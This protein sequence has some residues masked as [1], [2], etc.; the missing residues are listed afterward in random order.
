MYKVIGADGMEYGPITSDQLQP[1]IAD[2]RVNA[3][4]RVR[5][6][7]DPEWRTAGDF[8]ELAPALQARTPQPS[9]ASTGAAAQATGKTSR[10]AIT[11]LVLGIL[12][13][14]TCGVT[15]VIGLIL[16]IVAMTSIR[17]NAGR[18]RGSGIALA[19][20]II[21]A[22]S[23]LILPIMAAM[24]LPA[25]AKAKDRAERISCINNLKQVALAAR[26]YASDREERLPGEDWSDAIL[27]DLGNGR[28]LVCPAADKDHRCSYSFNANLIGRN[29]AEVNPETVMFFESEDGWNQSGGFEQ[30]LSD[31]RHQNTLNFAFADGSVRSVPVTEAHEL[32]WDP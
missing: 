25:I 4:T 29:T 8:L 18:L 24:F 32:R 5:P 22:C 9:Y 10:M 17:K 1:W 31:P 14:A 28:A 7:D 26:I 13:L 2:G 20:T 16:G 27:A 21:S 15:G 23:I 3:Q 11:S 6:A 19:G 30:L 12:G